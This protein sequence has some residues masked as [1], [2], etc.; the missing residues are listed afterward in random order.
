MKL[1]NSTVKTLQPS[2]K[3][4]DH[5]DDALPSFGVRVNPGGSKT[6]FVM[7]RQR[8]RAK[9]M[10]LG[11]ANTVSADVARQQA[12]RLL[13]RVALGEELT[14]KRKMTHREGLE[15]DQQTH[16]ATKSK[17]YQNMADSFVRTHMPDRL[18]KSDVNATPRGDW[19]ELIYG[20]SPSHGCWAF[21][22]INAYL[23]RLVQR[24]Y[25][26]VNP[27]AGTKNPHKQTEVDR[28]HTP[29]E[30][31][32]IRRFA[33]DTNCLP[34]QF[35]MLTLCRRKE[36]LDLRKEEVN[37][38][39]GEV[40]LPGVRTKNSR[41]HTIILPKRLKA[42]MQLWEQP[43]GDLFF[44][45]TTP[46]WLIKKVRQYTG[47]KD[48]TLHNLRRSGATHMAA[49][50]VAPH[51]IELALNHQPRA[52]SGV[53]GVYNRYSYRAEIEEALQAYEIWVQQLGR[54]I[55]LLTA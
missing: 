46:Y 36:G 27:L 19:M 35:I 16:L 40:H 38:N 25:A 47:I 1:T 23:N 14:P 5:F 10:T 15:W 12:R 43:K 6:Y 17:S 37:L 13:G 39:L 41:P 30:L 50:G 54:G 28:V 24:G 52:I 34:L 21:R 55:K 49:L 7:V 4:T 53:A 11:R 20:M 2:D 26:E 45:H 3:Q 33:E 29:D 32:A 22:Y 9:R 31:L 44:G 18:L 51:V 42:K 8:G 48:F